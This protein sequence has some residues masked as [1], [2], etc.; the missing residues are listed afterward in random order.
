MKQ[1]DIFFLNCYNFHVDR[2]GAVG[3][4]SLFSTTWIFIDKQRLHVLQEEMTKWIFFQSLSYL[5]DLHF[6]YMV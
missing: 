6:S 5:E 3:G 1:I 2:N 4:Q